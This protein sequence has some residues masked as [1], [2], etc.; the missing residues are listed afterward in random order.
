MALIRSERHARLVESLRAFHE[1]V[2][3]DRNHLD[4][5][6]SLMGSKLLGDYFSTAPYFS[7]RPRFLYTDREY[8]PP[9]RVF[10]TSSSF[11]SAAMTSRRCR[12]VP[13]PA[14]FF[15]GQGVSLSISSC[16]APSGEGFFAPRPPTAISMLGQMSPTQ[17]HMP[18]FDKKNQRYSEPASSPHL[19]RTS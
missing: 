8:W 4:Q 17:S 14:H 12:P 6:E 7:Q 3:N 15:D 5:R 13:A 9:Q 10:Y 1:F 18:S 2:V 11:S 16:T 19:A